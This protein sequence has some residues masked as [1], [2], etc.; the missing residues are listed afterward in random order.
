MLPLIWEDSAYVFEKVV[1]KVEK[2]VQEMLK[3]VKLAD[4]SAVSELVE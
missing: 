1:L 4:I 2:A 3:L